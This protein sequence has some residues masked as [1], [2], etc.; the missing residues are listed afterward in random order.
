M[1]HKFRIAETT[2]TTT[3]SGTFHKLATGGTAGNIIPLM[4][5]CGR[6]LERS[7]LSI[8]WMKQKTSSKS[9]KNLGTKE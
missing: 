8:R 9:R 3:P 4:M 6:F 7:S 1:K 2:T 5:D